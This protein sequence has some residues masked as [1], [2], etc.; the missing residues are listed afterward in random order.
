[1]AIDIGGGE[2]G[3]LA[4]MLKRNVLKNVNQLLVNFHGITTDISQSVYVEHLMILSDLYTEGFRTFHFQRKLNCIF[5]EDKGKT[6][7]YSIYMI[8][9]MPMTGPLEVYGPDLIENKTSTDLAFMYSSLLISS[10]VHCKELVRL[11]KVSDG[12]WDVCNDTKYRLSS[13]CLVYSFGI[14]ND[15]SFDD[16]ISTTFGCETHSFDPS[17][18]M[19]DHQRSKKITFHNIGLWGK[20]RGLKGTWTMMNLK[21]IIDMLGHTGKII[22]ILKMDI[23]WA[24]WEAI[25]NMLATGVLRN[26]RQLFVEFHGSPGPDSSLLSRLTSLRG[27]YDQGF[28]LFWSHPNVVGDNPKIF[29][30]TGR[31]VSGCYENYFLN[32]NLINLK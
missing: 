3:L 9:R 23:E 31:E 2:T 30:V 11:G 12:G 1:M 10:Q 22:D 17:M 28:K 7:C 4:W 25:P 15:W 6:G 24:E 14:D 32:T 29:S 8:R 18:G 26:V 19:L 5:K 16:D 27:I 21:E 20:P 13:P